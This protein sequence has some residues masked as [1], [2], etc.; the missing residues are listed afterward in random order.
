[1][2]VV[3]LFSHL[4]FVINLVS[5][6]FSKFTFLQSRS[7]CPGLKLKL[8]FFLHTIP[9]TLSSVEFEI[10]LNPTLAIPTTILI[11]TQFLFFVIKPTISSLLLL[12]LSLR[13]SSCCPSLSLILNLGS[14]ILLPSWSLLYWFSMILLIVFFLTSLILLFFSSS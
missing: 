3:F 1:M 13:I 7:N 8:T 14:L 12:I 11:T 4:L 6:L 5:L 9:F 2:N 10:I